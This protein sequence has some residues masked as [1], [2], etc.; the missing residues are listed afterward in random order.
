MNQK[1][2]ERGFFVAIA[3]AILVGQSPTEGRCSVH[4]HPNPDARL[5]IENKGQWQYS[6][7]YRSDLPYGRVW[8][9][10]DR[11]TF[12][13]HDPAQLQ[14]LHP[15][16]H[17]S[18]P[19]N[20]RLHA[21]AMRFVGSNPTPNVS[22]SHEAPGYSNFFI[23]ND[24]SKWASRVKSFAEVHYE[25]LYDGIG[26]Y[27]YHGEQ[28]LKYDYR[29]EP[30]ADPAQIRFWY[31]GADEAYLHDGRVVLL[32]S[33][34]QLV[35]Y[36]PSAWQEVDGVRI[37]VNTR[38]VFQ[39][40]YF[41]F[42]F[43]EGYDR[44]Y[45]LIIDPTLV[46]STYTGSTADNWGVTATFDLAGNGYAGGIANGAG[47]PVSVGAFDVSYSPG[48]GNTVGVIPD[49]YGSDIAIIKY[50][51]TGTAR[52]WATYIGGN[53]NEAPHSM[54]TNSVQDLY[55]FGATASTNFPVGLQS[56]QPNRAG[57]VDGF[58]LRLSADG[59]T[60]LGG[61]YIG[62]TADDVINLNNGALDVFYG[63]DHR[64]EIV[65]DNQG[66]AYVATCTRSNNF[67]IVG[68]FD[69]S[70]GGQQDAVVFKFNS[71]MTQLLWSSYLGGGAL[72]A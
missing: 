18:E 14:S 3:A 70:L 48:G 42:E 50:N 13:F 65:I 22:R 7:L 61:S 23:G 41:S 38:Y 71:D 29:I 15:R 45:P 64:G 49:T 21:V 37:P 52:I 31:D 51:P 56:Y 26:L 4:H 69:N 10:R 20:L 68:G 53:N 16:P 28:G 8:L 44:D 43:P 40:G 32:T 46:F 67:P 57:G 62:G 39:E 2:R 24:R 25:N 72:D 12:V 27:V 35:E 55:I 59:T 5:F 66:N 63:D 60:L 19:V 54:V 17:F 11:F 33:V 47:Y 1:L 58:V 36:I 30:G 34:G 9:E 6:I